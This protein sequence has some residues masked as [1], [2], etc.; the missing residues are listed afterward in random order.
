MKAIR[1]EVAIR[2]TP[3]P[4][5]GR[6]KSSWVDRSRSRIFRF[7]EG[8]LYTYQ[9]KVRNIG[10]E[11]VGAEDLL[12][13]EFEWEFPTK[14]VNLRAFPFPQSIEPGA[15]HAFPEVDHRIL[16]SGFALLYVRTY[17]IAKGGIEHVLTEPALELE[18]QDARGQVVPFESGETVGVDMKGGTTSHEARSRFAFENFHA[19]ASTDIKQYVLILI[20]IVALA[21]GAAFGLLNYLK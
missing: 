18:I 21:L 11:P 17:R 13:L 10:D 14:Q 12:R 3:A 20:A 1:L 7:V 5:K 9:V 6:N 4:R 19:L 15:L 16:S 2:P 8:D